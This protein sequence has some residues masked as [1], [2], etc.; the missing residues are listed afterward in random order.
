MLLTNGKYFTRYLAVILVSTAL[1]H[2]RAIHH[3]HAGIRQGV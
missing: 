2:R 1:G 3:L